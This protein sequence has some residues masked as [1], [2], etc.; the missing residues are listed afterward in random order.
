MES[1][2][3]FEDFSVLF[4]VYSSCQASIVFVLVGKLFK[5]RNT[6]QKK[7]AELFKPPADLLDWMSAISHG[8]QSV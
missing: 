1:K 2:G 3:Y 5:N 6:F 7:L 4:L 8:S